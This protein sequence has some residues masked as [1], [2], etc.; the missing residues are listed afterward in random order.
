MFIA[1]W[2]VTEDHARETGLWVHE[3]IHVS[4]AC[5]L[6]GEVPAVSKGDLDLMVRPEPYRQ[7]QRRHAHA[8]QKSP[9]PRQST[10]RTAS[11]HP[12]QMGL[13]HEQVTSE[14]AC[15]A[16]WAGRMSLCPG[17]TP[18]SSVTMLSG[19]PVAVRTG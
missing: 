13:L 10:Q 17:R 3:N 2:F 15:P 9:R 7:R 4:E 5:D 6:V 8:H 1:N 14:L 12:D 11:A 19:S 16:G 18:E